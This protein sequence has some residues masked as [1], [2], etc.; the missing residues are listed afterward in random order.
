MIHVTSGD[1]QQ[2]KYLVRLVGIQNDQAQDPMS[3]HQSL[4]I[5]INLKTHV[6][7]VDLEQ[8]K[9]LV[10]LAIQKDQTQ[11][12]LIINQSPQV[13]INLMTHVTSLDLEQTK[14]LSECLPFRKIK[15]KIPHQYR[16]PTK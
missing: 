6:T 2:P 11:D 15:H 14:H 16:S 12:P 10:R 5:E 4:Q 9:H 8:S 3:I 7:S 1:L 13:E